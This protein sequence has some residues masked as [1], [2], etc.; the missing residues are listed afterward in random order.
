MRLRG[1]VFTA[2]GVLLAGFT[3]ASAEGGTRSPAA[4]KA[5]ELAPAPQK[6]AVHRRMKRSFRQRRAHA[7]RVATLRVC[8]PGRTIAPELLNAPAPVSNVPTLPGP[9]VPGTTIPPA[10]ELAHS[11]Q[12]RAREYSLALSRSVVAAGEVNVEF[13]TVNAEDPHDLN[14]RDATAAERRLFDE[15]PAGLIPPPREAFTFA[16]GDYVVFCSLPGHEAL[17]MRALLRV[18]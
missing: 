10:E 12:V 2:L 16:P 3:A 5:C 17:G 6:R 1:V 18:R 14:L 11:V 7:A 4:P 9:S 8:R 15:T 13:H